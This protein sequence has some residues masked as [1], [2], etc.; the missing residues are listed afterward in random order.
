MLLEEIIW[1]NFFVHI[2]KNKIHKIKSGMTNDSFLFDIEGKR[3]ILRINGVGSDDLL[4][5]YNEI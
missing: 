4:N 1:E 3:Y 2:D 5:R